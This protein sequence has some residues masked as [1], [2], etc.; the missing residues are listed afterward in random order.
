MNP[1]D[2]INLSSLTDEQRN[3]IKTLCE[4]YDNID[5]IGR[6][7]AQEKDDS[8]RL[9]TVLMWLKLESLAY[10]PGDNHS[11]FIAYA[12]S[13]PNDDRIYHSTLPSGIVVNDKPKG[14]IRTPCGTAIHFKNYDAPDKAIAEYLGLVECIEQAFDI[15]LLNNKLY[16]LTRR[17]KYD[18]DVGCMEARTGPVLAY[19][20]QLRSM[21]CKT[22]QLEDAFFE[23]NK[24]YQALEAAYQNNSNNNGDLLKHIY[25]LTYRYFSEHI[26]KPCMD[27]GH[28]LIKS[29]DKCHIDRRLKEIGYESPDND[30]DLYVQYYPIAVINDMN[31]LAKTF[32]VHA[33]FY[34]LHGDNFKTKLAELHDPENVRPIISHPHQRQYKWDF[35]TDSFKK[36]EK[37]VKEK[38]GQ[39]VPGTR[40]LKKTPLTFLLEDGQI[41]LFRPEC[42]NQ[43]A[44]VFRSEEAIIPPEYVFT[45]NYGTNA[46]WWLD[47]HANHYRPVP[48]DDLK[49]QL[50]DDR[51]QGKTPRQNEIL[52][53]LRKDSLIAL[54]AR[55]KRSDEIFNQRLR[56]LTLLKCKCLAQEVLKDYHIDI[57]LL[58]LS[59]EDPVVTYPLNEQLDDLTVYFDDFEYQKKINMTLDEVW[60]VIKE[61]ICSP[62]LKEREAGLTFLKKHIFGLTCLDV[63]TSGLANK[64]KALQKVIDNTLMSE[65]VCRDINQSLSVILDLIQLEMTAETINSFIAENHHCFIPEFT[66]YIVYHLLNS[67]KQPLISELNLNEDDYLTCSFIRKT[68]AFELSDD[69]LQTLIMRTAKNNIDEFGLF[70]EHCFCNFT[71]LFT[72]ADELIDLI[73]TQKKIASI[74]INKFNQFYKTE[75]INYF[76][77]FNG[78]SFEQT[79]DLADINLDFFK[80]HVLANKTELIERMSGIKDIVR[81]LEI[82]K[83]S[84]R[85]LMD[86][87]APNVTLSELN[88]LAIE[89]VNLINGL[90]NTIPRINKLASINHDL[91][92]WLLQKSRK[93][94]KGFTSGS[95]IAQLAGIDSNYTIEYIQNTSPGKVKSKLANADTFCRIAEASQPVAEFLLDNYDETFAGLFTQPDNF[96]KFT[97]L[98]PELSKPLISKVQVRTFDDV[99]L[100]LETKSEVTSDFLNQRSELIISLIQSLGDFARIYKTDASF[101]KTLIDNYPDS[102]ARLFDTDSCNDTVCMDDLIPCMTALI[103]NK[104]NLARKI[105]L[106]MAKRNIRLALRLLL[107]EY[108]DRLLRLFSSPENAYS[109][110]QIDPDI[111]YNFITGMASLDVDSMREILLY[112]PNDIA[113][114]FAQYD[115]MARLMRSSVPTYANWFVINLASVNPETFVQLMYDNFGLV[116]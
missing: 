100:L 24:F 55:F 62:V 87:Y 60:M 83:D 30:M 26:G 97:K 64:I 54:A 115:H 52:A 72:K 16:E 9:L 31:A 69:V 19:A 36:K 113:L 41:K 76:K 2:K 14:V 111:A 17:F 103:E 42:T 75:L 112:Q 8:K 101:T 59:S 110:I 73:Q 39:P 116:Q 57:P 7:S 88:D 98:S 65:D 44:M 80:S 27:Y 43:I 49:K 12:I 40:H 11:C 25:S 85:M 105:I 53:K 18:R 68:L 96:A 32:D 78:F 35:E 67:N 34:G 106:N 13:H 38:R 50:K 114:L 10:R 45:E 90:Y 5:N 74:I 29:L 61:S 37:P 107:S 47:K 66:Q 15:A 92:K 51:R 102:I 84:A 33:S 22:L 56:K 81:V 91:A 3:N 21:D 71:S 99:I 94:L 108:Q 109:L 20:T 104:A 48:L 23:L 79:L 95:H 93:K 6:L 46:R 28:S 70:I 77:R 63:V 82:D 86:S 1:P 58:K 89:D 4:Y